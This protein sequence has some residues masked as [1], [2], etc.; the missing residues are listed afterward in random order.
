MSRSIDG[1]WLHD[2]H[3]RGRCLRV[4]FRCQWPWMYV[5]GLRWGFYAFGVVPFGFMLWPKRVS[6]G[7]SGETK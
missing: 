5:H 6:D 1:R 7:G 4:F 3:F 2:I